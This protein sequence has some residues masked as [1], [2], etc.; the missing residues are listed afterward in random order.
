[1]GV[2]T[3]RLRRLPKGNNA[4]HVAMVAIANQTY[5]VTYLFQIKIIKCSATIQTHAHQR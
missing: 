2:L 3:P 4:N 1:M 5:H